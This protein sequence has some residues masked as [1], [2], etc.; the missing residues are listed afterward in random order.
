[1]LLPAVISQTSYTTLAT[2]FQATV[3]VEE[4]GGQRQALTVM[5]H[6]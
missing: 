2:T 1:M 6:R 4:M 5:L 3:Y